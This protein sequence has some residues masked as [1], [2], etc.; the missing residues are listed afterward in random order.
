MN[1]ALYQ[2]SAYISEQCIT[3]YVHYKE[4]NEYYIHVSFKKINK[5]PRVLFIQARDLKVQGRPELG[6][7]AASGDTLGKLSRTLEAR[8]SWESEPNPS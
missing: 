2:N 6:R 7:G 3:Y 1:S 4:H 5:K 8:I